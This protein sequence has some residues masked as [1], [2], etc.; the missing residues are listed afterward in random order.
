MRSRTN[1]TGWELKL[2][3]KH[4]TDFSFKSREFLYENV[5]ILGTRCFDVRTAWIHIIEWC[6]VLERIIL[7][8]IV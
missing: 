8:G 6:A 2:D 7:P 1:G 3:L 5:A 4:F